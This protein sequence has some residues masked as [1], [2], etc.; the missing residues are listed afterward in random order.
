MWAGIISSEA[1]AQKWRTWGCSAF[2]VLIACGGG[3]N[4][5]E[6]EQLPLYALTKCPL[7]WYPA[8]MRE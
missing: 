8:G 5:A 6:E 1:E 7:L 4:S 2:S 3:E